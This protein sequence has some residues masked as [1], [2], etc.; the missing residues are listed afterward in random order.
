MSINPEHGNIIQ[1]HGT[2]QDFSR[3]ENAGIPSINPHAYLSA[4]NSQLTRSLQR[5]HMT[6]GNSTFKS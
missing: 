4:E 5:K 3:N 2:P 6:S 1:Y